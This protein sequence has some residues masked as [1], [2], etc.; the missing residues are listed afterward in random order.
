MT[1]TGEALRATSDA[2]L[3]DLEVLSA[4][5][6]EKRS[7]QPGDPRLVE[8][9]VR[10]EEVA[11]RVLTGSVRQRQLTQVGHA[12]KVAGS[13][14]APDAAIEDVHRPM[15]AILSEWREA[16]R[17]HAAAALDSADAAEAQA[18]IDHLREEYRRAYE[19]ARGD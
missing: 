14:A 18:V 3:R 6:E 13:P 19:A 4:I 11:G 15:Q 9:A 10:I 7:L 12:Q 5:E 8:L 2:L 1:D 16:E 17:R